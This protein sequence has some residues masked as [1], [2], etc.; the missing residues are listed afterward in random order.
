ML[1]FYSQVACAV[2]LYSVSSTNEIDDFCV[3]WVVARLLFP[4]NPALQN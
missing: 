1:L 3:T 2:I 4:I